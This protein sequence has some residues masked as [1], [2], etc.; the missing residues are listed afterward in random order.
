MQKIRIGIVG[1][2][3]ICRLRHVPGL[4]KIEG[5]ELVVVANRSRE[6]SERAAHEFG[7]PEIAE[8][9]RDVVDRDDLDAVLVGTW[10]CMHREVSIAALDSGKHVFCQARMAMNHAEAKEMRAAALRS[11]RVAMLCPVPYGLKYDRTVLRLIREGALGHVRLARVQGFYDTFAEA[12]APMTWRKDH[13]LSGLNALT[14]GMFIEVMHRWFGWTRAV[15]ASTRTFIPERKD[16][17]GRW[18]AVQIPDQFLINAVMQSG[19]DVQYAFSG[20]VRDGRDIVE[21]YGTKASLHYDVLEDRMCWLR[22]GKPGEDVDVH[23][24]DAYD[25]TDWRVERDFIDAI[26]EGKEY[27]PNFAD[28]L[29]YMQVLQAVYDAAERQAVVVLDD[30]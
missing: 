11:N 28:G 29:R 12:D 7:I 20:A 26:R 30:A 8:S 16:A 5:V 24:G 14:L 13:R 22:A 2:G 9:W 4:R 6:S 23:P 27:H 21:I 19:A 18:T 10:P 3:G 17:E 25:V 15:A 1:L